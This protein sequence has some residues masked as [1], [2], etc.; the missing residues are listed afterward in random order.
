MMLSKYFM[1]AESSMQNPATRQP[2]G[3]LTAV[4]LAAV[5]TIGLTAQA[6]T[7]AGSNGRAL[8]ANQQIG[9]GG[10]NPDDGRL[11]FSRRNDVI[12]GNVGAAR[13]FQDTIDYRAVGEFGDVLGSD[14]LFDFRAQSLPS[15]TGFLNATTVG[16]RGS[17]SNIRVFRS[18]TNRAAQPQSRGLTA[19]QG[20]GNRISSTPVSTKIYSTQIRTDAFRDAALRLKPGLALK[21]FS[22]APG[23]G[24]DRLP[25]VT[26]AALSRRMY[27]EAQEADDYKIPGDITDSM[28]YDTNVFD[29][30]SK[31]KEDDKNIQMLQPGQL[32]PTLL[33]GQQLQTLF[34]PDPAGLTDPTRSQQ[35][36]VS[37]FQRLDRPNAE[38]KGA[39]V[40]DQLLRDIRDGREAVTGRDDLANSLEAPT[41]QQLTEA[42]LAY[43]EIMKDMYGEDYKTRRTDRGTDEEPKA[44]DEQVRGVVD[45]LNYDLP[46]IESLAGNKQTRIADLTREAETALANGKYLTAES[47]YRQI[48]LSTK[49]DPLPRAGLIHAQLGAGMFR[50][51]GMN[52][53]ALFVQ[54]PELIAA[55]YDAKLLP[56]ESRLQW[57]QQELQSVIS[58]GEG[59]KNAP[60]L[61]AYLGYQADSRQVVRYGLA[62]AQS[63]SPRDPMLLVIR[64]IWLDESD[65]SDGK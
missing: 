34:D 1:T 9:S 60:L 44:G 4:A 16:A 46:R 3:I 23:T 45:Q 2:G 57:I 11:D 15:S 51:A 26:S 7:R 61:L 53:R 20:G 48:L 28:R 41:S 19:P 54:H 31:T 65:T 52:L 36:L 50:S 56:P 39:S 29:P 63:K 58:K 55:R 14:S 10:F 37:V 8:D 5:M 33:I 13:G 38:A 17:N 24:L 22:Q 59:G 43:E 21:A 62:L 47:R 6:Q 27:N 25:I 64:E 35:V 40:Y 49:G 12:T 42:E 30:F 32:P 18:F